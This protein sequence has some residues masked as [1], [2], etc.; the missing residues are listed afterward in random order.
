MID[1]ATARR[2]ARDLD[3]LV[4]EGVRLG[5]AVS[6]GPDSLALLLLA[7]E[8]RPGS[9][10]AASVD[11]R[12][13]P[14]SRGE[15]QCVAELCAGMD[16]PHRI[17]SV[18]IARGASVQA[19]ARAARYCA[20]ERW[21]GMHGLATVATGHHLDDQAE[22]LLMRLARGAGVGGL[23]GV[24]AERALGALVLVRPLLGWR[25]TE[26][27]AVVAASGIIAIDDPSNRDP[28]HDRSRVRAFLDREK[29]LGP[30]RLAASA[31]HL[32]EAEEAL[33]WSLN[34]LADERIA[35]DEAGLSVAAGD[36]PNEY[37]RR[38]LLEAMRRL[39]SD[40]VRGSDAE[41]ALG[42]LRSGKRCTLGGL[43]LEGGDR[44]RLSPAP[45]ARKRGPQSGSS[46]SSTESD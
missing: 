2:F 27:E 18:D 37:Q 5:I 32:A 9:V 29:W 44:W 22:T 12:L 7:A 3:K 4:P 24:R 30:G 21:G 23:A 33:G 31:G 28:R 10:E 14:D 1:P 34:R 15:A 26:L 16:V 42:S 41:R 11:H 19:Q 43:L 13:R 8:V 45:I 40:C 20:L 25:K 17:L 35:G 38:L 6:G 36:L 39:G 46:G